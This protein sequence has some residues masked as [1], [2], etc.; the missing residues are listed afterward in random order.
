MELDLNPGSVQF[1]VVYLLVLSST[2]FLVHVHD[3]GG[4]ELQPWGQNQLHKKE[5]INLIISVILSEENDKY[6]FCVSSVSF[7]FLTP[8]KQTSFSFP[9]LHQLFQRVSPRRPTPTALA[10][11]QRSNRNKGFF[12]RDKRLPSVFLFWPVLTLMEFTSLTEVGA[13]VILLLL[14]SHTVVE[15]A[16][17]DS[18]P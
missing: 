17:W 2:V 13:D 6:F 8:D 7:F 15:A 16:G 9:V 3:P 18:N 5:K 11:R 14:L 4:V 12:N 10:D 1:F